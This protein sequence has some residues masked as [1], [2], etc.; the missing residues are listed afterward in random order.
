MAWIRAWKL[1]VNAIAMY[2]LLE[3]RDYVQLVIIQVFFFSHGIINKL[4]WP[5]STVSIKIEN[6]IFDKSV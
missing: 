1:F 5:D 2:Q 4:V 6:I 3:H